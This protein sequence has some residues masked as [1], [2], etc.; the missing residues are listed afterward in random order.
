MMNNEVMESDVVNSEVF[1]SVVSDD[2]MEF[3]FVLTVWFH[4]VA[5]SIPSW[6]RLRW[7]GVM[8]RR[9]LRT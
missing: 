6:H 9:D 3:V 5:L 2:W 8:Q 7:G 1:T 4:D